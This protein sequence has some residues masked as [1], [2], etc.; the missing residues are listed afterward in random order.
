MNNLDK[1]RDRIIAYVALTLI[2]VFLTT[3]VCMLEQPVVALGM[4]ILWTLLALW[5][6]YILDYLPLLEGVL[7]ERNT[8]LGLIAFGS[9]ISYAIIYDLGTNLEALFF[10]LACTLA[11]LLIVYCGIVLT[12]FLLK[13]CCNFLCWQCEKRS[14]TFETIFQM[15]ERGLRKVGL[16]E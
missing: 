16:A 11:F 6:L 13:L 9:M 10:A 8:V 12:L 7:S 15:I 5:V 4:F 14:I 3:I 1:L 2:V